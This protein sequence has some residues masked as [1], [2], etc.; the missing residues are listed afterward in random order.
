MKSIDRQLKEIREY[1][2]DLKMYY[3]HEIANR[4]V[5]YAPVEVRQ[6]IGRIIDEFVDDI[7]RH[8]HARI[9]EIE[10]DYDLFSYDD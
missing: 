2:E 10:E 5:D 3:R 6:E 1:I 7:Y 9:R 4:L 8:V